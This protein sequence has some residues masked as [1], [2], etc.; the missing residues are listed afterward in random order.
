MLVQY[1]L[2]RLQKS[3]SQFIVPSGALSDVQALE[4]QIEL[5]LRALRDIEIIH[6]RLRQS[7]GYNVRGVPR[8]RKGGRGRGAYSRR[9]PPNRL[10][11]RPI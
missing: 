4:V 6:A 3:V 1:A 9:V 7:K 8:R 11:V 2:G 5:R 10:F